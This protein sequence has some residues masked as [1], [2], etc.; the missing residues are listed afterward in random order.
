[1][2]IEKHITD[3]KGYFFIF[4]GCTA[5]GIWFPDQEQNSGRPSAIRA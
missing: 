5:G 2:L 3:M 1:M 4:F